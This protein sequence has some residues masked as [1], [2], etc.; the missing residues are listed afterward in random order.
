MPERELKIKRIYDPFEPDDGTRVLVDRLWPRGM[1]KREANIG[2]WAK[3]LAPSDQLRR[4]FD[5]DP[6]L[7]E[8]FQKRYAK[9]LDAKEDDLKELLDALPDGPVTF[10]YASRIEAYNNALALKNYVEK[11]RLFD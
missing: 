2:L 1:R 9:E 5:H 10:V 4:W 11:R 6:D 3:D 8:E 7:W